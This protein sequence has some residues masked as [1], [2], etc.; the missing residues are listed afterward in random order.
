MSTSRAIIAG[1]VG[2]LAITLVTSLLRAMGMPIN[3][4]M[5]VGSMLTATIGLST[6][7]LG[8]L[9]HLFTGAIFGI[10]YSAVFQRWTRR[11]DATTGVGLGAVHALFSGLALGMLPAVHP[12]VPEQMAAPGI[13]LAQL[14]AGGV[15]VYIGLHL[16][17]GAVVG[18]M[19]A[20]EH[21][22]REAAR[23]YP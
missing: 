8:F 6:W 17:F 11:A 22:G 9:I 15:I 18:A 10:L 14:G 21:R 12:L 13:F 3:F 16:L 20:A 2:A 7:L 1:V 4:E 19:Y 5:M 23:A